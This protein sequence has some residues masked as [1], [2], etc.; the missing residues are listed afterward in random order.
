MRQ[1]KEE[2][3]KVKESEKEVK[4]ISKEKISIFRGTR[5]QEEFKKLPLFDVAEAVTDGRTQQRR[6]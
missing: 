5:G 1:R 6:Y 3:N 2:E 4:Y